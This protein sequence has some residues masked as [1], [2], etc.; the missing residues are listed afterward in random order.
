VS[1]ETYFLDTHAL[2]FWVM[3][4]EMSETLITALD[5]YQAQQRLFVSAANFWEIALLVQKA[6][7][8]CP[9]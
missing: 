6:R 7:L 5:E 1:T 4:K 8:S 2:L 3:R 9:M